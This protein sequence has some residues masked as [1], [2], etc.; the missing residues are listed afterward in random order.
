MLKIELNEEKNYEL[1][2]LSAKLIDGDLVITD[3]TAGWSLIA[4]RIVDGKINLV[5]YNS[6]ADKN[7]NTD[8][9]GR[10]VE[11]PE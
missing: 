11:V 7:Y 3:E 10:L 9:Q 8:K 5:R 6:I 1:A 4:L 2:K